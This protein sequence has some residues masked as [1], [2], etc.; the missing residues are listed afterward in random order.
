MFEL[1]SKNEERRLSTLFALPSPPKYY[2][3]W[4]EQTVVRDARSLTSLLDTYDRTE[5][6]PSEKEAMLFIITNSLNNLLMADPAASDL[7]PRGSQTLRKDIS[8]VT[9]IVEYWRNLS[10]PREDRPALSPHVLH[11]FPDVPIL[12]RRIKGIEAFGHGS[13]RDLDR[14]EFT[15]NSQLPADYRTFLLQN[16]GGSFEDHVFS[17]PALEDAA[18]IKSL[19]G[20]GQSPQ[21]DLMAVNAALRDELPDRCI[22]IGRD[23]YDNF[24]VL[25][26]D[27][28]NESV[29]YYDRTG[30]WPTPEGAS[31]FLRLADSFSEFAG[32]I[33]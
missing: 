23:E 31:K 29:L 11:A 3:Y 4:A 16:N 2:D 32:T 13:E 18:Y 17:L 10:M 14:M 15:F 8:R 24:I 9:E 25:C 30:Q 5:L 7:W 33:A 27:D 19:L 21:D 6:S 22:A 20:F 28:A 12:L 26:C 1:L